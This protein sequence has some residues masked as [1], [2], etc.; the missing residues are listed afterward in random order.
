MLRSRAVRFTYNSRP[1]AISADLHNLAFNSTFSSL[2]TRYS[3]SLSYSQGSLSFGSYRPLRHDLE[4]KFAATPKTF[5]LYRGRITAG[6]SS[7]LLS[8]TVESYNDP[9]VQAHYDVVLDGRQAA[10][11]LN[12]PTLPSGS[13]HLSGSLHYRKAAHRSLIE[14]LMIDGG[15]TSAN[16]TWNTPA[17]HTRLAKLSGRYSLA[18]GNAVVRDARAEVLGG[19][20]TANGTMQALGGNTHSAFHVDM[21][22]VS[23]AEAVQAFQ[24]SAPRSQ[25]SL[26]GSANATATVTWGKTIN[27]LSGR[28]DLTLNGQAVRRHGQ[29]LTDAEIS[30]G[31]SSTMTAVTVPIQGAFHAIYLNASHELTLNDSSLRSAQSNVSL[32]GTIS[33]RSSLAVQLQVNDL[34]EV[35]TLAD[36]FLPRKTGANQIDLAGSASFHG[37]VRGSLTAPEISGQLVAENLQYHGTKWKVLR[38]GVDLSG[39]HAGLENLQLEAVGRGQI[40]GSAGLDLQDWKFTRQS[41]VQ[42]TLKASELDVAA[43]AA[44]AGRQIPVTGSLSAQ[45]HLHGE[46]IDP[47]GSSNITLS[48]AVVFGE[49]VSMAKVDLTGS[50]SNLQATASVQLAAGTVQARATANPQAKTFTAQINSSGIDV[51][52][53]HAVEARGIGVKGDLKF[54]AHAQGSFNNPEVDATLEVPTLAIGGQIISQTRLH[55]NAANHVANAELDSSVVNASLR[56]KAQVNLSGDYLTDASLDTQSVPLQPLLA[57]Y[58]PE[59][60]PALTGQV[61]IH[62]TVHGPLKKRNQLL[63]HVKVP[64]LQIAYGKIQLAASPIQADLQNGIATLQPL[65]IRGTDT[66]LSVQGAFPVGHQAPASLK[67]QGAV[68]L[69]VLQIFDPDLNASGQLK[70]NVDSHSTDASRLL[71]GEIDI[72][73]ANLSTSTSPVGL[74]HGN[75]VLKISN[76]RLEIAKLGGTLGGGEVTAQGSVVLR[77]SIR[78]D[79]G[80]TIHEAKILYPQGVRETIDANLRL[81]GSQ[82]H[83]A[84]GGSVKIADMSFT[85]A[86][87]LNSVVSQVSGGVQTPTGP[88]FMQNL[89]LNIALNS[90][91]N[92]NLVSRT[93]SVDGSANLQIRGTAAQPVILGRVNLTSGDVIL[94]GTR[95]VLTGGTVQFIN[96]T[97]TA[98]GT[99]RLAYHDD[100]GIQDRSAISRACRPDAHSIQFRPFVAAGRH[101]QFAGIR[102]DYGSECNERHAHEPAGREP[103]RLTSRKPGDE[104]HIQSRGDFAAVHQ[105]GAGGWLGRRTT[106]GKSDDP[107]AGHGKFIRHVLNQCGNDSRANNTGAIQS[108]ATR[109]HQRDARPERWIC[110]R[111][112]D[113]EGVVAADRMACPTRCTPPSS[114]SFI[115]DASN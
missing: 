72:A 107:A 101:Y 27:D 6:P 31:N 26:N 2:L 113:Q 4:V 83:S 22:N 98:A 91:G 25:V 112:P 13:V 44:L 55:V 58:A 60:G 12:Q 1:H 114:L 68:N 100:S 90:A 40:A 89:R 81:T 109:H 84:L 59:E 88:G 85:P 43:I 66:E 33:R 70:V 42:L 20:V 3:G 67:V 77:P 56:G 23:L 95:F 30:T 35:A 97:M 50:G 53:L 17:V 86:F 103:G 92:A 69:Q 80:T 102:P 7:A 115:P 65:T 62:A 32:N 48:N 47:A 76:D 74:Q 8:A 105:P 36:L 63:L 61:E 46:A 52:K 19:A 79:V 96:P 78:F 87:D 15:V 57:A 21:K 5:T 34:S 18:N 51:A 110:G 75:G 39:A 49:P 54:Q 29:H 82:S 11:I 94:H 111:H 104:P 14:S 93:L 16:L 106:R 108:F 99:Q 24:Q 64:T 10:G 73:D 71:D 41:P 9:V 45:A 28:A 38:T 37:F